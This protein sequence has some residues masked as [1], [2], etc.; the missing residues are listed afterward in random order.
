MIEVVFGV[1]REIQD[2]AAKAFFCIFLRPQHHVILRCCHFTA[3]QGDVLWPE[4]LAAGDFIEEGLPGD[5]A[6]FA[7]R[8]RFCSEKDIALKRRTDEVT[9]KKKRGDDAPTLSDDTM[10]THNAF[11]DLKKMF[12]A[13]T[14]PADRLARSDRFRSGQKEEGR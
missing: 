2:E 10:Q 6:N 14:L 1:C 8:N 3:Q 5:A 7:F 11:G 9:G 13:I 12:D 4:A